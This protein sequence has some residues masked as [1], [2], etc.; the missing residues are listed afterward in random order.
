MD[1]WGLVSCLPASGLN[2][3][4]QDWEAKETFQEAEILNCS[5]LI[6]R[7]REHCY[8]LS[9]AVIIRL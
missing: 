4:T 8:V 1:S 3:C 2:K 6:L 5:F 9:S 7:E